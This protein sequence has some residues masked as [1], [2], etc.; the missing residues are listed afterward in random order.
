MTHLCRSRADVEGQRHLVSPRR[1]RCGVGHGVLDGH[2]IRATAAVQCG[3]LSPSLG[4][5]TSD[6]RPPH[7]LHGPGG[8]SVGGARLPGRGQPVRGFRLRHPGAAARRGDRYGQPVVRVRERPRRPA[9]HRPRLLGRNAD[10]RA[11]GRDAAQLG[12]LALRHAQGRLRQCRG[13]Q[14]YARPA[15][16]A[17]ARR[18]LE[19]PARASHGPDR[20]RLQRRGGPLAAGLPARRPVRGGSSPDGGDAGPGRAGL[21]AFGPGL[22]P[23]WLRDRRCG[24]FPRQP[25]QEGRAGP[26]AADQGAGQPA[27][28]HPRQSQAAEGDGGA[29]GVRRVLRPPAASAAPR[30]RSS[31]PSSIAGCIGCGGRCGAR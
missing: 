3:Q 14:Q 20:Q 7:L 19:L 17:D 28:R 23:G 12:D 24:A 6:Q 8:E 5:P 26:D 18:A 31:S 4:I 10:S 9:W 22:D 15:G 16:E 27:D 29:A 21:L 30:S 2:A 13:R 1:C 11:R 25:R